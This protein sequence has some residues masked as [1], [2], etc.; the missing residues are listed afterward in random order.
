MTHGKYIMDYTKRVACLAHF[1]NLIGHF[2]TLDNSVGYFKIS[3]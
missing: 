3:C 2:R 1:G